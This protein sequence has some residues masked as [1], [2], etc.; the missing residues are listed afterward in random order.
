MSQNALVV[1][2]ALTEILEIELKNIKTVIEGIR[3]GIDS[4]A[5]L[6]MLVI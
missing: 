6:N 1:Y 4:S 3:Y 5:I 2:L